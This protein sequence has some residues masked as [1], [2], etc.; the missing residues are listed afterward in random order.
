[1]RNCIVLG[2]GRSGTSATAGAIL[3]GETRYYGGGSFVPPR[4]SNPDGTYEPISIRRINEDILSHVVPRRPSEEEQY[5]H[6]PTQWQRWLARIP[7]GTKLLAT[8]EQKESMRKHIRQQPFCLKDPRFS[9]T[10]PAWMD[11]LPAE[12]VYICLFRDPVETAHSILRFVSEFEL[13][14]NFTITFKEALEAWTLLNGHIIDA[15][16]A[17]GGKWLFLPFGEIFDNI[18]AD[19][20]EKITKS[21]IRREG[22]RQDRRRTRSSSGD[23]VPAETKEVFNE[24]VR[25]AEITGEF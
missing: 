8:E 16:R 20:I 22:F 3:T 6:I 23:G 7:R 21:K 5:W 13:M 9:Y 14:Q 24:L 10:L 19:K 11:E 15:Y 1:M 12:V 18:G 2:C 25:L 4:I 17:Y